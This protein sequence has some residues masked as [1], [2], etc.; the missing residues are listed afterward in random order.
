M[1]R[2]RLR[3]AR[4]NLGRMDLAFALPLE[5]AV[6]DYAALFRPF[7]AGQRQE[8]LVV[9]YVDGSGT[10]LELQ[11]SGNGHGA[12]V[13]FPIRHIVQSAIS[14]SASGLI[15]AHNHPSGEAEPSAADRQMTRRLAAAL[16]PLDIRLLDHLVFGGDTVTGF[17]ARGLL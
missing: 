13:A 10:L 9:A 4:G 14:L 11:L 16:R 6:P 12:A 7:L 17:R 1:L 5:A 3:L 2:S 8:R 15:L